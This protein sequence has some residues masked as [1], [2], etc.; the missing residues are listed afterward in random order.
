M[1]IN[2]SK[3]GKDDGLSSRQGTPL[4]LV[5]NPLQICKLMCQAYVGKAR[6]PCGSVQ[7]CLA[8]FRAA[9][10]LKP[11]TRDSESGEVTTLHRHRCAV[12]VHNKG[13]IELSLLQSVR[14][15]VHP[16]QDGAE[17]RETAE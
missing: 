9:H 14:R 4:S 8:L 7:K 16:P 1:V 3:E 17:E 2:L 12:S 5:M 6:S 10:S 13:T 11:I 15:A